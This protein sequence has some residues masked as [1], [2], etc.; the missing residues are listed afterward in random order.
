MT[1]PKGSKVRCI[2]NEVRRGSLTIGKV[3]DV[4]ASYENYIYITDDNEEYTPYIPERFESVEQKQSNVV[5][6]EQ[7][8]MFDVDDTLIM[9]DDEIHRSAE[10]RIAIQDPY[11]GI[12]V[13]VKPHE[14]HV[15]L[16]TQMKGR[17]RF[18]IV[19]SQSGAKWAQAVV[20]ALGLTNQ[21]DLILT[22][23]QGYVDDL[24]VSKWMKNHIYIKETNK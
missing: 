12:T 19:W 3:Y 16:L 2:N 22:K 9:W 21:V 17:G 10:D 23:P 20:E 24:P 7:I 8:Y 14:R 15:K 13:H 1:F 4:E 11:D 18:V 6:N 5:E